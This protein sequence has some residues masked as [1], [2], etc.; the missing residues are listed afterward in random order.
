MDTASAIRPMISTEEISYRKY[1]PIL[2]T[3]MAYVDVGNGDPIVFRAP[4]ECDAEAQSRVRSQ[5]GMRS[6]AST[7][8]CTSCADRTRSTWRRREAVS[9]PWPPE[10]SSHGLKH[11][12][13][14]RISQSVLDRDAP[15]M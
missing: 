9:Y 5:A 10:E 8:T 4:C 2:G 1:L 7:L 14:R 11:S 15:R 6:V 12:R 3:H 13:A